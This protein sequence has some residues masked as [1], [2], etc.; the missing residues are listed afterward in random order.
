MREP[1]LLTP[2]VQGQVRFGEAFRVV[3]NMKVVFV[4]T[5]LFNTTS[6]MY[7]SYK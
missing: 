6:L 1:G 2:Q 5:L 3:L 7:S 4:I